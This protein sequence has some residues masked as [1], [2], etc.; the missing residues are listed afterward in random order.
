MQGGWE[1]MESSLE[2]LHE[3]QVKSVD[4]LRKVGSFPHCE[5]ITEVAIKRLQVMKIVRQRLVNRFNRLYL[6]M[7]MDIPQARSQEVCTQKYSAFII[8]RALQVNTH[9]LL[10]HDY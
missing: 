6:F 4:H 8:V 2:K 9:F 3:H 10:S 7:G 5:K 1:E